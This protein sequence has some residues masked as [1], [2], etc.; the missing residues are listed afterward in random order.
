MEPNAWQ[1]KS[2][3]K[4]GLAV[5]CERRAMGNYSPRCV[6]DGRTMRYLA[7]RSMSDK[8]LKLG[9]TLTMLVCMTS[10][11]A[12]SKDESAPQ[13][14]VQTKPAD[15][16]S[17]LQNQDTAFS[18]LIEAFRDVQGRIIQ[19]DYEARIKA[20]NALPDLTT[21]CH[22]VELAK[23]EREL[24]VGKLYHQIGNL[25]LTYGRTH[26]DDSQAIGVDVPMHIDTGH[27]AKT[28]MDYVFIAPAA[29]DKDG[30]IKTTTVP[31]KNYLLDKM[32]HPAP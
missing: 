18:L 25:H 20:A 28:L 24:R 17:E 7:W 5:C 23:E 15:P 19:N 2:A 6:L 26:C 22:V 9:M 14:P 1:E 30:E 32:T 10:L 4:C 3:Q 21:R 11:S 16:I 8:A 31:A 27:A 29:P 13:S 12:E